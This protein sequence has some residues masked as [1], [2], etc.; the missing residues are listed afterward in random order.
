MTKIIS[1]AVQEMFKRFKTLAAKRKN[2]TI[3][4]KED[5]EL[6][7]LQDRLDSLEDKGRTPEKKGGFIDKPLGPGGK[8]KKQ[9]K[10]SKK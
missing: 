3:T 5:V 4:E 7:L 6:D 10:K 2:G 9:K 1:T 8:K